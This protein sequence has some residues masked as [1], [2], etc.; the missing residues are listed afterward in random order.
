MSVESVSL[1]LALLALVCLVGTLSATAAVLVPTTR[2]IA[3]DLLGPICLALAALIATVS[4]LGSLYY[5]EVANFTPCR[6]CWFQ[7]IAMYPLAL[8]LGIAAFA[9]DGG[10]RKYVMPPAFIGALISGY[11]ILIENFPSLESTSCDP[12]NP[13][14]LIWVKELGFL[15]I[16]TMALTGFTAILVLLAV[17]RLWDNGRPADRSNQTPNTKKEVRG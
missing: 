16:P 13:C 15:T 11:H 7:R 4:T 6:L 3:V 12:L 5:S 8:V 10:I 14:S 2:A 9:R 17:H 1:F